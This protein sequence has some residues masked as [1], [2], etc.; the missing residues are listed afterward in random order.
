MKPIAGILL[1][2]L[3]LAGG[4]VLGSRMSQAQATSA[5]IEPILVYPDAAP[6][7]TMGQPAAAAAPALSSVGASPLSP[8][9]ILAG[10]Q[11]IDTPTALPGEG[12]RWIEREG[13]VYQHGLNPAA[14]LSAAE[15]ALMSPDTYSDVTISASFYD[16]GNGTVGL[17]ARHSEAGFYRVRLH[18]NPSYD[19][20]AL[21]LE[22]VTGGVA[23]PLLLNAG[24]PLYQPHAWHT[25]A[26]S[27][28]GGKIL[29]TL[30]GKVVAEVEDLAPLQG[31]SAGLYTRALSNLFFSQIT[32]S[33]EEL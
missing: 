8:A 33:G 17:I 14:S 12:G 27:V 2:A 28:T 32:L 4:L 13:H 1:I 5:G 26:L 18:A 16:N 15:T 23:V 9:D 21:V 7:P 29:V 24:E 19:G 25:L 31:G 30:D 10:W 11:V 6:T 3:A 20:E 22:K